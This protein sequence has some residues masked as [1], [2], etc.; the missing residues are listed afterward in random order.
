MLKQLLDKF[1]EKLYLFWNMCK[2]IKMEI[3]KQ[4]ELERKEEEKKNNKK[5]TKKETKDTK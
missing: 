2:K 4:K 5:D 3:V 1:A